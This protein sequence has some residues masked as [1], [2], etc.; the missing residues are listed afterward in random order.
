MIWVCAYTHIVSQK[1]FKTNNWKKE[2]APKMWKV[3]LET[4]VEKNT[5]LYHFLHVIYKN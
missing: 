1:K 2:Q 5:L 4:F 3:S